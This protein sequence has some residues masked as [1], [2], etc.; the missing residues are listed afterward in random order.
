MKL[1]VY[2]DT[3][4]ISAY[5]DIRAPER[6]AVTHE[7]WAQLKDFVGACHALLRS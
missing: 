5:Y 1:R 7:F 3:S 6:Q 2:L 4:V